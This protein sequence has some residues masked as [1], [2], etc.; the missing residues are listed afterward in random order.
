MNKKNKIFY[1]GVI[2]SKPIIKNF[3]LTNNSEDIIEYLN[4]L[5]FLKKEILELVKSQNIIDIGTP[6]FFK[7]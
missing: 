2:S 4:I 5:K 7:C 6:F 1:K 3:D